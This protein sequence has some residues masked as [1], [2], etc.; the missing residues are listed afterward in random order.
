MIEQK[1]IPA[2]VE[3]PAYFCDVVAGDTVRIGPLTLV[4][5]A[6]DDLRATIRNEQNGREV[7]YYSGE[8]DDVGF[9]LLPREHPS[10]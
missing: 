5:T 3:V 8:F 9:I 6:K 7:T 1:T 2:P 10:K 4:V